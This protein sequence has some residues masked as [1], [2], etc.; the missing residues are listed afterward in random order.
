MTPRGES[1]ERSESGPRGNLEL[2]A[3]I[4]AVVGLVVVGLV[5]GHFGERAD[6]LRIFAEHVSE[7]ASQLMVAGL[8]LA[9]FAMVLA[10][11]RGGQLAALFVTSFREISRG[12]SLWIAL[13]GGVVLAAGAPFLESV[14]GGAGRLKMVMS[15]TAAS[16]TMVGT[17]LAI[18]LPALSFSREMET[19]SIFVTATKPAPRWTL[20]VGKLGGVA[21]AL[22]LALVA[23]GVGGYIAGNIALRLE[24]EKAVAAGGRAEHV[25]LTGY[26]SRI[27][28]RPPLGRLPDGTRR[29]SQVFYVG[30]SRKFTL[31]VNP[32]DYQGEWLVLRV[33]AGPANPMIKTAPARITCGG[34]SHDV[35]LDRSV[36]LDMIIPHSAVE[37]GNLEVT[38]EPVLDT[39]GIN[40][41]LRTDPRG[42]VSVARA[43][44]GLGGSLL[45][46]LGLIWLQLLVVAAVTLTAASVLSFPVAVVSGV[47]TSLTGH[48]SGLAVGILRNALH[49]G[50]SL[51]GGA[52]VHGGAGHGVGGAEAEQVSA[53]GQVIR[54]GAAG[55]LGILP[56]F[57]AGSATDF[58]AAGTYVPWR[59]IAAAAVALLLLRAV[60]AAVLGCV[61]FSRREVGA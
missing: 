3:A 36:P 56:D 43:G 13:V 60:P 31:P 41:G 46:A 6:M 1:P 7:E 4:L 53:L 33:H 15:L 25:W 47:A 5:L 9:L 30:D 16:A 26:Y 32:D 59:F 14:G 40:R 27:D 54:Q 19:R 52:D 35:L 12:G 58:V 34:Q 61:V 24:V 48:L 8:V 18:A 49:V 17:L 22:A 57:E 42:A 37:D 29:R 51:A 55:L 45:K 20:Y 2:T 21:A 28:S 50:Q 23:L 39:E 38:L 11:R 10:S 44:N